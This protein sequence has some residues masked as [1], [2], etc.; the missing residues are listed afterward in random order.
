[1]KILLIVTTLF[2]NILFANY[3]YMIQ[4]NG[5]IDMHGGKGENLIDEK[6]SLS[7]K[8]FKN[9]GINKPITPKAPQNLIKEDKKE[10]KKE[11]SK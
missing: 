6:N 9:I 1:M 3:N 10:E 2:A 11:N 8:D 4:D 5:K 7:N